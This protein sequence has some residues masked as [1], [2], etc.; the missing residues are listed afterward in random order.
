MSET[1]LTELEALLREEREGLLRGDHAVLA[2]LAERKEALFADLGAAA[3]SL[4][5]DRL[6]HIR[7]EAE[8][9]GE[10]LSAATRGLKAVGR[11]LA[12][13]RAAHGPLN[14]YSSTGTRRTLGA[15]R[16]ALE[17]RA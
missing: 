6:E 9:N 13:I 14:T 2:S 11:R 15:G 5:R 17:R 1:T 8:R 7:R 3:S 12:E 4:P 16:G 10:L